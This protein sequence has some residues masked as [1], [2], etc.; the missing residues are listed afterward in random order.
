MAGNWYTDAT[1]RHRH[2][3]SQRQRIIMKEREEPEP[4]RD[5]FAE[6]TVEPHVELNELYDMEG[7]QHEGEHEHEHEGISMDD[8][9]LEQE[10]EIET[11]PVQVAREETVP[12]KMVMAYCLAEHQ[13][14]LIEDPREVVLANGAVAVK[15]HDAHG[16]KLSLMV[17]GAGRGSKKKK[18]RN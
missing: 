12:A 16:H 15:G 10:Q 11:M 3:A 18:S 6:D 4:V 9:P 8:Y 2:I 13:K 5:V 7:H 1:G 17:K 14:V